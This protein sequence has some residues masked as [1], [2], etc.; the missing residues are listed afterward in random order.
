MAFSLF[1]KEDP[2]LK[3]PD[4][5]QRSLEGGIRVEVLH[6]AQCSVCPLNKSPGLKNPGMDAYGSLNPVAYI[7]GE[8]PGE[9]EDQQGRPF[10]GRAG[11]TLRF[12]LP[13]KHVQNLRW[14]NCVRT[15]PPKNR[16][17]TDVELECCRP[18]IIRDIELTKPPAILGFGAVPLHWAL[19][20]SGITMWR[21]RRIPIKV[22]SHTCWFYPMFHPQYINYQRR[23]TPDRQNQYGCDEEVAFARDIE[24]VFRDLQTLPD[25]VVHTAADAETE[26]NW[27]LGNPGDLERVLT[28]IAELYRYKYVGI[29]YETKHLR[30]YYTDAKLLTVA[31]S[32]KG[33]TLAFPIFHREARWQSWEVER[34][35]T[36]L[37]D[38]VH[39]SQSRKIAHNLPFEL[40]WSA[41]ELGKHCVRSNWEDTMSQ[42]FVL[43]ER[44]GMLSL[45]ML[46]IQYFGVNIKELSPL[47]T[48]NLDNEPLDLVL[49]Y[50]GIDAKYHRLLFMEQDRRLTEEGQQEV[51]RDHARRPATM[52]LTSLQGVP[53]DWEV[54]KALDAD[55]KQKMADLLDEIL[56]EPEAEEFQKRYGRTLNPSTDVNDLLSMLD[57]QTE[58]N[59]KDALKRI[60][61]PIGALVIKWR[62]AQKTHSTY[63][64]NLHKYAFPDGVLHPIISA[65]KTRTSRT[66]G[67]FPNMQNWS[68]RLIE[69]RVVRK[70][71][72]PKSS[73]IK[74]VSF[75]YGQIQARNVA[76]ESH[77]TALVKAF[78]ER[79]DIH[80]DW[81]ERAAKKYPT[82]VKEGV[83][84]L[85]QD[86]DLRKTYRNYAKNHIVFASLFGASGRTVADHLEVPE[87]VGN[88]LSAEFWDM[89]PEVKDWH[90]QVRID[91]LKTGYV[92][93][94]SGY[95]RYAP[96]KHNELIN[97]PIQGDEAKIVCDAMNR[98]SALDPDRFQATLE[99]HDDLTF[100]WPA[101]KV[102]EY[103]E[104][105]L[106][107]MLHP[108]YEWTRVVPILVE[109]SVGND[110]YEQEEVGKFQSDD[111]NGIVQVKEELLR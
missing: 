20:Q 107:I 71:V 54:N 94:L 96:V 106:K 16:D 63:I 15:R 18:S 13:Q 98:L 79:Y 19:Q 104:E 34:I 102:E 40:E 101:N 25:P 33:E 36:A 39:D 4:N 81:M 56:F 61:A 60:E 90:E 73:S 103:A 6:K 108:P 52:V 95:R 45:E 12:R 42:A 47:D 67:E 50:N 64:T 14:N 24:R 80:S 9:Q 1:Y 35:L 83:K 105:A 23:F 27:V 32:R 11:E 97:T 70:Q 2:V 22:G 17:P 99:I 62:E 43:D 110:W 59:D 93:G 111:W 38:F 88:E 65:C 31:L 46:C 74:V 76:M 100:L 28:F 92:T 91:Y 58:K 78:W 84:Q 3:R 57:I 5:K 44:P 41:F 53:I 86:K 66:S 55:Y 10:V 48:V 89:F 26:V 75:D 7:L 49:R 82:W 109:M 30:P 77:D 68:K 85:A 87:W 69:H 29:D 37:A 72:K 21:G 51:Y 8:A